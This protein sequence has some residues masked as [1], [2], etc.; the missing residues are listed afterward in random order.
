MT[1]APR[2]SSSS[3]EPA[4]ACR[5]RLAH[6]DHHLAPRPAL[7]RAIKRGD[8]SCPRSTIA[9]RTPQARRH[10]T[11]LSASSADR[12]A[13]PFSGRSGQPRVDSTTTVHRCE[14][15]R[16]YHAWTKAIWAMAAGAHAGCCFAQGRRVDRCGC[17]DGCCA[18]CARSI[19]RAAGSARGVRSNRDRVGYSH[20]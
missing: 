14:S 1:G 19:A 7:V 17:A 5:G 12:R 10:E 18:P 16:G 20:R 11:T 15:T 8:W 9:I 6:R 4:Q 13:A 3:G 2:A